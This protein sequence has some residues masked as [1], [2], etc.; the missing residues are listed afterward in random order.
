MSSVPMQMGSCTWV[1]ASPIAQHTGS[2]HHPTWQ[3]LQHAK[4]CDVP[5]RLFRRMTCPCCQTM[6]K[7]RSR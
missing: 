6:T 1:P 3:V 4:E 2:I 7:K 5:T